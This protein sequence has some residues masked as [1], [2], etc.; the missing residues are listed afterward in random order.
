VLPFEP[1]HL[2]IFNQAEFSALF[3]SNV[4]KHLIETGTQERAQFRLPDPYYFLPNPDDLPVIVATRMS[5]SF[6]LLISAIPLYT[7]RQSAFQHRHNDKLSTLQATDL[8][9]NWFSD[10]GI[11]SNFPI[12]F[13][14]AWLPTRPTFGIN[15]T[16]VS[17][18]VLQ[19]QSAH[20][21]FRPYSS[22]YLSTPSNSANLS[23][24][25]SQKTGQTLN[26]EVYLPEANAMQ[27]PEWVDINTNLFTF[28]WQIFLTAQNYRDTTQSNLPGYRERIVQLRLSDNEGGLN[29]AMDTATIAQVMTKGDA[30][31][32]L[33]CKNF[34]FE[35]HQWVRFRVLMGLLEEKLGQM[36]KNALSSGKFDFEKLLQTNQSCPYSYPVPDTLYVQKAMECVDRIRASVQQY[37]CEAGSPSLNDQAPQPEA[38]LRTTPQL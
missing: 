9:K 19:G 25:M 11:S 2:F 18:E 38:A 4:V 16:S 10:G 28:I 27:F 21:E 32:N 26:Q 34:N 29:L 20:S 31:G 13:F 23:V 5:L 35:H 30:A 3:P 33:L 8:Q 14:D 15:L 37:W 6:P 36:E 24:E 17:P 1:D 22:D 12:H 7:I